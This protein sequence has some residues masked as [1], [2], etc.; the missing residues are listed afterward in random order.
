MLAVRYQRA[1]ERAEMM[2]GPDTDPGGRTVSSLAVALHWPEVAH[3]VGACLENK[4]LAVLIQV[5]LVCVAQEEPGEAA[6]KGQGRCF[7]LRTK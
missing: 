4:H 2:R 3:R 1:P 7:Q 6:S 5:L